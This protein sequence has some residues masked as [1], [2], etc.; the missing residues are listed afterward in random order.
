MILNI[1]KE[2]N[3]HMPNV[4]CLLSRGAY[5]YKTK[6]KVSIVFIEVLFLAFRVIMSSSVA[7]LC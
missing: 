6:Q 7:K 4:F 2:E 1:E 3:P 5:G